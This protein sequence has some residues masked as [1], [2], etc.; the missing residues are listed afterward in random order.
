M[1]QQILSQALVRYLSQ[2]VGGYERHAITDAATLAGLLRPADVLLVEG[3]QRFSVAVKY[4]TQS[5]WS[6]AALFVGDAVQT[7]PGS[8]E[9]H[10]L[11]EADLE[12]GVVSVPI[13]KYECFNTRICRPI[14][15]T[16]EDRARVIGFVLSRLGDK[17]DLKNVV[18]LARYLLPT[19]PVP[20]TIAS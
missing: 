2:P 14:G 10:V 16:E 9:P 11:V 12:N 8:S 5:T 6:H 19:P 20:T 3:E 18:D 17:Y 1:L 4:L 7:P 15:L 13:S